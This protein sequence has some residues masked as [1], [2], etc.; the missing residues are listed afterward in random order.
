[1]GILGIDNRT[2]NWKTAE[3]F[4]TLFRNGNARKA[5]AVRLGEPKDTLARQIKLELFWK[6][7]R[8][9]INKAKMDKQPGPTP[10][11]L[12]NLYKNISQF[13]DL[14][15]RVDKFPGLKLPN[16][17]NYHVGGKE[18]EVKLF[19][20]LRNTEI[21]IVLETPRHLYIGEAKDESDFGT[22]GENV[23]VHQ[24]I[25]QYVVA[26]ILVSLI[27]KSDPEK[28]KA[29]VPFIVGTKKNI[30]ELAQVKF[31]LSQKWIKESNVLS[32]RNAFDRRYIPTGITKA[33]VRDRR[34]RR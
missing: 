8:D 19:N 14:R 3:R 27:G 21:D 26:K 1:M 29:I 23:L 5:F 4:A 2:E 15:E 12:A 32:W 30:V 28:K 22:V 16:D 11:N 6:G 25:R 7:I 33:G 24:L 13:H 18:A 20:N 9:Y 10:Q 34:Y 31:M 17:W